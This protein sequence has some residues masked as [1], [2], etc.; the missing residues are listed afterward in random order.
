MEVAPR[1]LP[2]T[3]RK[4]RDNFVRLTSPYASCRS[5]AQGTYVM[6]G[7]AFSSHQRS[8]TCQIQV[9]PTYLLERPV[10]PFAVSSAHCIEL[11]TPD[12]LLMAYSFPRWRTR[13]KSSSRA[14]V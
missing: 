14:L 3:G 5:C 11:R 9:S 7:D 10:K 1:A 12:W 8:C 6:L 4:F 2:T 13:S